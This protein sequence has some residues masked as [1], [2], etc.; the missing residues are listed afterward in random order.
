MTVRR[1]ACAA[2][3]ALGA[4]STPAPPPARLNLT[5]KEWREDLRAFARQLPR[6]HAAPY[7]AI[8]KARFDAEVAALDA[9]LDH[10]SADQVMVGIQ[11]I[12]RLV[13]DGHTGLRGPPN[14]L[15]LPLSIARFDGEDRVV[16]VGAGYDQ[17]LGAR[18]VA[19]GGVPIAQA[20]ERLLTLT[21][22]DE[23]QAL[24][25]DQ[26]DSLMSES[27]MLH[28]LEIIPDGSHAVFTL[29]PDEGPAF[30][31]DVAA[32]PAPTPALHGLAHA[33]PLSQT[34]PGSGFWCAWLEAQRTAYCDFR[35]YKGLGEASR[36]LF[37]LID[38]K[39]PDKVVVDLRDN[40]GGD[41]TVGLRH[42]V[43]PLAKIASVN[44]RG[45]LF[46]LIGVKTFSAAM[47]NASHF[48]AQTQ[49]ML[50]GEPIGE[51]PNS[52]QENAQFYLPH[53]KLMISYSTRFYTFAPPGENVIRPD[54]AVATTWADVKAGRDPVLDWVLAYRP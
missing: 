27:Q 4:C 37:S 15:V 53:S 29:A 22:Y 13:G 6:R 46:V 28:G 9:R 50:V 35:S 23:T 47:S 3:L 30:D 10:L 24:R 32:V 41:Y 17:A 42:L 49:A 25:D 54:Q 16:K 38:A 8:S 14:R 44:R 26:T 36:E 19:I 20:R 2:L 21:P 51:R 7:H 11:H 31:V 43:H 52:W 1:L 39:H 18:V 40:G 45:H 5:L 34:H 33:L 12:A 48:R